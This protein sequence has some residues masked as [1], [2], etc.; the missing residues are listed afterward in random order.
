MPSYEIDG[1]A[2]SLFRET[3]EDAKTF[4]A[5]RI[6]DRHNIHERFVSS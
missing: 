1:P 5:S 6:R 2:S 4:S 3:E